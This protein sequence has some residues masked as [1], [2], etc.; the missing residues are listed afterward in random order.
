MI[1]PDVTT[2]GQRVAWIGNSVNGSTPRLLAG[3]A[4][5]AYTGPLPDDFDPE[6][7][8]TVLLDTVDGDTLEEPHYVLAPRS[9][10]MPVI[11]C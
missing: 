2:E 9:R 6:G 5:R 8:V 7:A 4:S 3:A 11:D 10:L 1:I